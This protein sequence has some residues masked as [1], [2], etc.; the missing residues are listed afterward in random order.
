[1]FAVAKDKIF[2]SVLNIVSR[3]CY[4]DNPILAVLITGCLIQLCF[5]IG[6]QAGWLDLYKAKL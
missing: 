6:D 3:G 5:L 1:M 2:G 4:K